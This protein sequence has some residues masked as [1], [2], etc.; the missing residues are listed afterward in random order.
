MRYNSKGEL[1]YHV[2]SKDS[3]LHSFKYK[4]AIIENYS[5]ELVAFYEKN[6]VLEQL[7]VTMIVY[8]FIKYLLQLYHFMVRLYFWEKDWNYSKEF[9]IILSLVRLLA[10]IRSV[11]AL[12][13]EI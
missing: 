9:R 5:K 1:T 11:S 7:W 10:E 8:S 12:S 13:S 6:L 4:D 3:G 2:V